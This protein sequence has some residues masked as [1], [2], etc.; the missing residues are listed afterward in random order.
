MI[1]CT[2]TGWKWVSQVHAVM[3]GLAE[4]SEDV[5]EAMLLDGCLEVDQNL[6]RICAK[7]FDKLLL[8]IL[9]FDVGFSLRPAGD[10]RIKFS[11]NQVG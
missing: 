7:G 9:C 4:T 6:L 3:S 8:L 2:Y 10:G 11:Q 1:I 5:V